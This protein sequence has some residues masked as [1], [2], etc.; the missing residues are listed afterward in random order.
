MFD[1]MTRSSLCMY[2]MDDIAE[3]ESK[4]G[5]ASAA[6]ASF[7]SGDHLVSSVTKIINNGTVHLRFEHIKCLTMVVSF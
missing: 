6:P 3:Y 2:K 7:V 1:F 4:G 5:L